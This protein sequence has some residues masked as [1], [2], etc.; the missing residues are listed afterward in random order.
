[1]LT[2]DEIKK[3]IL[4]GKISVSDTNE[5]SF[6]KPNSCGINMVDHVFEISP[7]IYNVGENVH[8]VIYYEMSTGIFNFL[9]PIYVPSSGLKIDGNKLYLTRSNQ[10]I[11][12]NG[13]VPYLYGKTDLSVRGISIDTN[14]SFYYSDYE[15][16]FVISLIATKDTIIYP[17][18][19][20]GNLI[21]K[22][23]SDY[24]DDKSGMLSGNE[25]VSQMENKN[26]IVTPN[27]FIKINPNSVNV[28]LNPV[29]SRLTDSVIDSCGGNKSEEIII[30]EDGTILMPGECYIASTNEYTETHGFIPELNGRSS[31]G[32]LGMF[33]HC[34]GGL[35]DLGYKG[36]WRLGLRVIHPL[37]IYENNQIAQI[38]YYTPTGD[39]TFDYS[40]YEDEKGKRR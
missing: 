4:N 12:S 18:M 5:N 25:I 27:D 17:N 22:K 34:S 2:T 33:I 13:F 16:F 1:M 28:S 11:T 14:N 32:R 29:V 38:C 15:G 6:L 7:D 30:S 10:E 36:N 9:K 8:D 40:D 21:F 31:G 39:V 3:Q 23:C 26:I 20:I 19:S 24:E 35:G 37:K